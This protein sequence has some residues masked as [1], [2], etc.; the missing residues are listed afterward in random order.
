MNAGRSEVLRVRGGVDH[1]PDHE[2][3]LGR[4]VV[5]SHLG[6]NTAETLG[7]DLR[8]ETGLPGHVFSS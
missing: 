4:Q 8:G 3:D 7:L 6:F 1:A 2:P 5:R